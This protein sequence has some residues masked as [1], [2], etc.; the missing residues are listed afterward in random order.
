MSGLLLFFWI[1]EVTQNFRFICISI[2]SGSNFANIY[3]REFVLIATIFIKWL[4]LRDFILYK[5][6]WS[7]T[8]L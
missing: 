2:N 7:S 6:W 3:A 4:D 8:D 5:E 1:P